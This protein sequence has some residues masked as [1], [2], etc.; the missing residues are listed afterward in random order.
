M[1]GFKRGGQ[2]LELVHAG[3]WI[4]CELPEWGA[5]RRGHVHLVRRTEQGGGGVDWRRVELS[6]H[7]LTVET[8]RGE[9]P[10]EIE[11]LVTDALAV[12]ELRFYRFAELGVVSELDES[13]AAFRRRVIGLLQPQLHERLERLREA[14]RADAAVQADGRREREEIAQAVAR[15]AGSLQERVL[16]LGP[17]TV[18]KAEVGWLIAPA[19]YSLETV[20]D[21]ELMVSGAPK[22]VTSR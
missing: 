8:G 2:E 7:P 1:L 6:R 13:Q 4:R 14:P 9:L 16:G 17:D 20:T 19:G 15:V 21:R 11:E 5:I 10:G 3:L 12:V 22:T 18:T